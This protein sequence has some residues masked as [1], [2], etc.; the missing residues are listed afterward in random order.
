MFAIAAAKLALHLVAISRSYGVFRDEFYY[1]ACARRLAW[2]YVDHPPFS[3]LVLA[4]DRALFG[5]GLVALR[6]IPAVCGAATVVLAGAIARELGGKAWAQALAALASLCAGV[7]IGVD[8]IYSMNGF[9]PLFWMGIA[10]ALTKLIHGGSPRLWIAVG[11]LA[12]LGVLDKHSTAFF[13]GAFALGAL[14]TG[15]RRRL[16]CKE[17]AFG[18]ALSVAL[19]APHV[20]WQIAHGWPTLEFLRNAQEHKNYLASPLEFL[21]GQF[22]SSN[23]FAF[24][25][26]VLGLGALL[27]SPRLRDER[28]LGIGA[29]LLVAFLMLQHAKPYYVAPLYPLL[30]AAG[31]VFVERWIANSIARVVAGLYAALLLASAIVFLP[32][33]TPWLPP[34]DFVAFAQRLGVEEVPTERHTAG[35]LPQFYADHFGWREL[36]EDV[37]RAFATLNESERA[38]CVVYAQ[39]YGE[40]GAIE[41]FAREMP[42]PPACT[43]HNSYYLWGLPPGPIDVVIGVGGE[44]EDYQRDFEQVELAA[45][46]VHPWAMPYESDLPIVVCRKPRAPVA[47]LFARTKHYN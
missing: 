17:L 46:H 22:K 12:G 35:R 28:A 21:S 31:A 45:T 36:A 41:Y 42:E 38:R 27:F 8:S 3:I 15:F 33:A 34:D 30:F 18:V 44:L 43:G 6:W 23:P 40:A 10:L 29:M 24:P 32:F 37:S 14:A 20:A 47:E 1:L 2:G 26:L 19:V 25:L 7:C 39:N 5:D 4:L 11:A 9:E 16:A 13:A